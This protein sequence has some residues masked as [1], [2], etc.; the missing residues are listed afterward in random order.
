ME[1]TINIF[2]DNEADVWIATSEDVRGLALEANSIDILIERVKLAVPELLSLNKV[3]NE[4][5]VSLCFIIQC[6]LIN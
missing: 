2:Q 1:Y 4:K 5:S 3:S 6:N